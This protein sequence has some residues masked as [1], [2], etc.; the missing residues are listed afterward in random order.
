[1]RLCL[2][3]I[4]SAGQLLPI[5]R[6]GRSSQG[7]PGLPSSGLSPWPLGSLAGAASCQGEGEARGGEGPGLQRKRTQGHVAV[8]EPRLRPAPLPFC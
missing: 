5:S 4:S 8:P 6:E 1:V 3:L 7:G 2:G